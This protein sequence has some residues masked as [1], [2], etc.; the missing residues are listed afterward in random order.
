MIRLVPF[1]TKQSQ[2]GQV[3]ATVTL[4]TVEFNVP[5]E[6]AYFKMPAK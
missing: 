4:D 1:T 2:N 6:D 5:V 3:V